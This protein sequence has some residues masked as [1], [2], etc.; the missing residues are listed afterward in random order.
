MYLNIVCLA[1]V[2]SDQ[3]NLCQSQ[4]IIPAVFLGEPNREVS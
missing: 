2:T 3:L 4:W 1:P